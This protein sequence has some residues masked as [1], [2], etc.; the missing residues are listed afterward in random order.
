MIIRPKGY[1][2]LI[3]SDRAFAPSTARHINRFH[4][5]FESIALVTYIPEFRCL[6]PYEMCHR[7]PLLSRVGSSLDAVIGQSHAVSAR[8]RFLL[9]L[10]ALRLFG[11]I[12]HWKQMFI[13][14]TFRPTERQG[15][16][17][18]LI[19]RGKDS[20]E[21]IRSGQQNSS[22]KSEVRLA[23]SHVRRE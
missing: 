12:R 3:Q 2:T 15:I 18:W 23:T 7:G 21:S 6:A 16:E 8:G 20:G 13:N 14:N 1:T 5:I 22:K 9:G 11:L 17:K 19:P 10:T 4:L